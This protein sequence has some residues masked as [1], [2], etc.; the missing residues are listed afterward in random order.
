MLFFLIFFEYIVNFDLIFKY[1]FQI[2]HI[3]EIETNN[4]KIKFYDF[5]LFKRIKRITFLDFYSQRY[6]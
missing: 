3:D 2:F 4:K 6:N 5:L 1:K